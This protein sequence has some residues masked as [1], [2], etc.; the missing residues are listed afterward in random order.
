MRAMKI[1]LFS[2]K[3]VALAV[4][5]CF[6]LL[7]IIP[8]VSRGSEFI[9]ELIQNVKVIREENEPS[10]IRIFENGIVIIENH[11]Y[12][13]GRTPPKY[14]SKK[15]DR[16]VISQ[17]VTCNIGFWEGNSPSIEANCYNISK[18]GTLQKRWSLNEKADRGLLSNGYGTVYHTIY[19]G[20]CGELANHR[21]YNLHTGNLVQE[22]T[23]N[24]LTV[25]VQNSSLHRLIGYKSGNTIKHHTWE[26]NKKHIGTL[27]YSSPEGILHQIAFRG[28]EGNKFKNQFDWG[29]F[30]N[31]EFYSISDKDKLNPGSD[32]DL[33]IRSSNFLEDPKVITNFQIKLNFREV[34]LFIPIKDDNFYLKETRFPTYEI[35]VIK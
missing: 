3:F 19:Y 34:T 21:F 18:D 6:I 10:K 5:A 9:T 28:L 22:Y 7:L 24:L 23:S 33:E 15:W 14:K 8:F 12:L 29:D 1:R 20:C 2:F 32:N 16:F 11:I 35:I 4:L 30:V 25:D 26:E 17:K 31:I 13:Y 27:T